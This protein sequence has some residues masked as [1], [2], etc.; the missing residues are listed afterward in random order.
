MLFSIQRATF[1]RKLY[2]KG[3]NNRKQKDLFPL[4]GSLSKSIFANS[5]S[6]CLITPPT[7]WHIPVKICY[8][9]LNIL[10]DDCHKMFAITFITIVDNL[11]IFLLQ[12]IKEWQV[13]VEIIV[14]NQ[15]AEMFTYLIMWYSTSNG[16]LR[17][18]L[19]FQD[20]VKRGSKK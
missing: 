2:D 6:F 11:Q 15:F 14:C 17:G 5:D 3:Q 10:L 19:F 18:S 1:C 13:F 9:L 4:F 8:W 12:N 16:G 7:Y 20:E